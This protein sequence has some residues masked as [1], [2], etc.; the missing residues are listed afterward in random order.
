M[1]FDD[2]P[3]ALGR[4]FLPPPRL[5]MGPG[6]I[7]CDPRVLSAMAHQLVGQF[8]P[9]MTACMNETMALYRGV[10]RTANRWTFCVDSTARGGI[11]ACLV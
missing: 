1:P 6:P 9:A 10:F 11:E 5:L 3:Q 7:T 4:T 2:L 8:D